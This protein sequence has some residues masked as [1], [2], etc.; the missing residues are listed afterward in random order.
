M[1]SELWCHQVAA[2]RRGLLSVVPRAVL[3]LLTWQE[4][5][6]KICGDP[7]ISVEAL[8]RTSARSLS[9]V[10]RLSVVVFVCA[11]CVKARVFC[12]GA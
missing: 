2:L 9:F 3:D 12:Q 5:E 1:N 10:C 8:R 4:L 7:E 11:H 6:K